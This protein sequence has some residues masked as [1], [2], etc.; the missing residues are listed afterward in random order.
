MKRKYT[1]DTGTDP[2]ARAI[3]DAASRLVAAELR[4][5]EERKSPCASPWD[6]TFWQTE[7]LSAREAYEKVSHNA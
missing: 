5:A 6:I 1:P 7:V 3:E 4:L 2:R